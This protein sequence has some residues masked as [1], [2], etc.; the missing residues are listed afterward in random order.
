MVEDYTKLEERYELDEKQDTAKLETQK[1]DYNKQLEC[2]KLLQEGLLK[3][4]SIFGYENEKLRDYVFQ[5]SEG[6]VLPAPLSE[7]NLNE[8][9]KFEDVKDQNLWYSIK[10]LVQHN[11][12]LR[13]LLYNLKSDELMGD[14]QEDI[15]GH[16]GKRRGIKADGIARKKSYL[17]KNQQLSSGVSGGLYGGNMVNNPAISHERRLSFSSSSNLAGFDS[18]NNSQQKC[19]SDNST[20]DLIKMLNKLE[21]DSK[22]W[23]N[24]YESLESKCKRQIQENQNLEKSLKIL[25]QE[26]VDFEA[27]TKELEGRNVD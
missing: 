7:F 24:K 16:T 10:D 26:N 9:T 1:L 21:G 6:K 3:Q 8:K 15:I 22:L 18:M 12:K 19:N 13:S 23:Q 14:W 27:K 4:I 17:S 20:K 5:Q 11:C 2:Q 25:K